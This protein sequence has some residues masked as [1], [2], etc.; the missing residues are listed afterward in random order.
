VALEEILDQAIAIVSP[1]MSGT[2]KA[3][4]PALDPRQGEPLESHQEK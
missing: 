2:Q 1:F 4:G 3:K